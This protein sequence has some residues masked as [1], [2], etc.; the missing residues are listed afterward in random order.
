[1]KQTFEAQ[2]IDGVKYPKYEVETVCFHCQDSVS[3]E[4]KT[5]GVCTNCGQSWKPKQSVA[6]WATSVPAAGTKLWS[7]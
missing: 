4:E 3:E 1:M 5:T 7:A 6:I 2:K